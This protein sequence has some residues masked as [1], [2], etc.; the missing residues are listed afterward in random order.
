[1]RSQ[2]ESA[3]A[4]GV[5]RAPVLVGAAVVV[6]VLVIIVV[7][8]ARRGPDT[9]S[10]AVDTM[11][12]GAGTTT[13]FPT[14][15]TGGTSPVV[16]N[17]DAPGTTEPPVDE[18]TSTTAS[19]AASLPPP[20]APRALPTSPDSSVP[21]P[22]APDPTTSTTA[23]PR[24]E[25]VTI[26]LRGAA[27]NE[28]RP[29]GALV[30]DATV[31]NDSTAPVPL[32]AG[33]SPCLHPDPAFEMS[34]VPTFDA[35]HAVVDWDGNPDTLAALLT[36]PVATTMGELYGVEIPLIAGWGMC[37]GMNEYRDLNPGETSDHHFERS[38]LMSPG[39]APATI[40]ARSLLPR[41]GPYMHPHGWP[42][43]TVRSPVIEMP[44]V[45]DPLRAKPFDAVVAA[46][47][48]ALAAWLA[49]H[50]HRPVKV[51]ATFFEGTWEL[52]FRE[53]DPNRVAQVKV[54]P[55]TLM[56]TSLWTP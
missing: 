55:A 33:P 6:L 22:S 50:E 46:V 51:Q 30:F 34:T 19:T 29:S 3:S 48:P 44:Y 43:Q 11:P 32:Y 37:G 5:P 21:D 49:G 45:D 35:S 47:L 54:D 17:V 38:L 31:H 10:L 41:E 4:R 52:R 13:T 28:A 39:P 16:G 42:D 25:D 9:A 53:L 8:V 15:T 1:M 7:V 56:V 14:G 12:G 24:A 18:S 23:A 27:T 36:P 20:T 2:P 26:D 40:F